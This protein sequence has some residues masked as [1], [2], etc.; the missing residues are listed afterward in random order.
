MRRRQQ[1]GL[2]VS[3]VQRAGLGSGV[4]LEPA[5]QLLLK[6]TKPSLKKR[7][8]SDPENRLFPNISGRS[9][10]AGRELLESSGIWRL[11]RPPLRNWQILFAERDSVTR[12]ERSI[13]IQRSI[14]WCSVFDAAMTGKLHSSLFSTPGVTMTKQFLGRTFL[15]SW[16]L[17]LAAVSP[18][19]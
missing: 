2:L 13:S 1:N 7:P 6:R 4:N 17:W 8:F 3:G 14:D 10:N 9:L 11:G 18:Y 5:I 19:D 12:R 16:M 15:F